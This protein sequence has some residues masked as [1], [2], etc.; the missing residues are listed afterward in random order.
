MTQSAEVPAAAK[1]R[2]LFFYSEHDGRSRRVEAFLAQVMQRRRNHE[3]F[4]IHRIETSRSAAL[5]ERF[6]VDEVPTLVVVDDSK[7][8]ARL[9]RPAGCADLKEALAPWLR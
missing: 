5:A 6:Q 3:T 4:V 8:R 7:V 9:V 1:P 2:L